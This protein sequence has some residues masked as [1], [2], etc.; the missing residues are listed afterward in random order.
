MWGVLRQWREG[1]PN[2]T[3]IAALN[4]IGN[5]IPAVLILPNVLLKNHILT[6]ALT[7]SVGGANTTGWPN[8]RLC[9]DCLKNFI[10]REG[11]CK[12]NQNI[13]RNKKKS[14]NH[15]WSSESEVDEM[16]MWKSWT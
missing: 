7:A 5:H 15:C 4:S 1:W 10:A 2:V 13:L 9:F 6:Q 11:S 16:D 8:E 12:T 14:I 3:M